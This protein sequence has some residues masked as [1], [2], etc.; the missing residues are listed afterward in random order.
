MKGGN[1]M[2]P[3]SEEQ[4]RAAFEQLRQL[5]EEAA[6]AGDAG[7][8]ILR[9]IEPTA[10]SLAQKLGIGADGMLADGAWS[11]LPAPDRLDAQARLQGALDALKSATA[12]SDEPRDA[13]SLM[14]RKHASN[15]WI[16]ALV[17]GSVVVVA[18]TIW[19]IYRYWDVATSAKATESQVLRMVVL[20]GAMGG[21]IHWMSSLVNFIGNGNL[22]RRWIPYYVLAP[23]Q[24]A[25]LAMLVYLLLRVGVLAPPQNAGPA[26]SLNLLGLYAF[27]GLTGL[28]AKQAIEMLRDVFAVIFKKIEAKDASGAVRPP[29]SGAAGSSGPQAAPRGGATK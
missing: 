26:Q 29:S 16:Y 12:G 20:M 15:P 24:G 3:Y 2:H 19:G 6:E 9:A 28:F 13:D 1:Q 10:Q 4:A 5:C 25:A 22:L 8:R 11:R 27:A 18:L 23:F 7:Q 21:A 14:Y 17:I